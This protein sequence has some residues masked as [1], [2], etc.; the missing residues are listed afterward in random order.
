MHSKKQFHS[1]SK[2]VTNISKVWEG[3]KPEPAK[4]K[5]D[6]TYF[7]RVKPV[8][9]NREGCCIGASKETCTMATSPGC[10]T[11][12][13]KS[14]GVINTILQPVLATTEQKLLLLIPTN[15]ETIMTYDLSLPKQWQGHKGLAEEQE[16]C[17]KHKNQANAL[18][19]I[20]VTRSHD[21]TPT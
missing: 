9:Y 20:P 17:N 13:G 15:R 2:P 11:H 18:K 12:L 4:V 10:W 14:D 8:L 6:S 21:H 16:D 5:K 1:R 19:C 3:S 7:C